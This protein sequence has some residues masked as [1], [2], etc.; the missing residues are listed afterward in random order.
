M[1]IHIIQHKIYH[2]T[3]NSTEVQTLFDD[4]GRNLANY[5]VSYQERFGM[6]YQRDAV[7][8]TCPAVKVEGLDQIGHERLPARLVRPALALLS[9]PQGRERRDGQ[10]CTHRRR[11][12]AEAKSTRL[13]LGET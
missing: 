5:Y 9:V 2:S 4:A 7:A 1:T 10:P 11:A 3:Q 8:R 6:R 12:R 13:P